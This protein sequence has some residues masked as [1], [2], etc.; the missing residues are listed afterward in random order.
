[1]VI[2]KGAQTNIV[3]RI[4]LRKRQAL[5]DESSIGRWRKASFHLQR[6]AVKLVFLPAA[7]NI[8]GESPCQY[9]NERTEPLLIGYIADLQTI[10]ELTGVRGIARASSVGDEAGIGR[11]PALS[12]ERQQ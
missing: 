3:H 10:Q 6:C 7:Q 9:E 2:E 11:R 5:S 4:R 8:T 12:L 1:M